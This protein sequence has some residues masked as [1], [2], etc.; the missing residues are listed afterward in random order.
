MKNFLII[1][2]C[3]ACLYLFLAFKIK[4]RQLTEKDET[5]A[6]LNS[7]LANAKQA[8]EP[9]AAKAK[10][11]P[12]ARVAPAPPKAVNVPPQAPLQAIMQDLAQPVATPAPSQNPKTAMDEFTATM[13]KD[14]VT[15]PPPFVIFMD[16]A[17]A[18]RDA[19]VSGVPEE[20][21]PQLNT[22]R[23][24]AIDRYNSFVTHLFPGRP[25]LRMVAR[26]RGAP[27]EASAAQVNLSPARLLWIA[28]DDS[29]P[30]AKYAVRWMKITPPQLSAAQAAMQ[31][32]DQE[33]SGQTDTNSA[34]LARNLH[35]AET[36]L[37]DLLDSKQPSIEDQ[38]KLA[39]FL[40]TASLPK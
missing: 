36:A 21:S 34:S 24:L 38:H 25:E 16:Q 28:V 37:K 7:Q 31:T 20:E 33:L 13:T 30:D 2:L 1:V 8:H 3:G 27:V 19:D 32:L 9:V 39:F 23:K 22:D 6:D 10:E 26:E 11:E 17:A 35:D 4:S 15:S 18:A 29:S 5:I 40:R 14:I 12:A